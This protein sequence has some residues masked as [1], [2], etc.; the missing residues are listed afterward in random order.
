MNITINRRQ[1]LSCLIAAGVAPGILAK[2]PS[3]RE[4]WISAQ[5]KNSDTYSMTSFNEM[6]KT[7]QSV[8]S[9]FRGHGMAQNPAQPESVVMFARRPGKYGIDVNIVTGEINH[10]FE[11]AK[12]RSLLGHGCF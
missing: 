1:F 11:I 10:K 8:I 4:Y 3:H 5:G 2:S 6:K 12:N 7:T 9:G